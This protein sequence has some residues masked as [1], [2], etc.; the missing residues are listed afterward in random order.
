MVEL[1]FDALNTI[2]NT[3]ITESGVIQGINIDSREIALG[4][5][6]VAI[7]GQRVDG[8]EYIE[9]AF[10]KG[11]SAALVSRPVKA[12]IPCFVVPDVVLALGKIAMYWREQFDIPVIGLTGSNG[13]TTTKNMI[14]MI[15]QK[16]C[17]DESDKVLATP[18]TWN[19]QISLP[20]NLCHLNQSHRYAVLEMGMD[21]FGEISALTH[22]VQPQVAMVLNAFPS[23][24]AG[25]GTVAGVA[26]AKAEIFEGLQEGGTAVLNADS[27]FY[28]YWRH[29]ASTFH[30]VTFGINAIAAVRAEQIQ[31]L[32]DS[33]RFVL[34]IDG[35]SVSIRLSLLGKHNVM[36]AL[37]AAAACSSIGLDLKT[38]RAGLEAVKPELQRLQLH[39]SKEG[40]CI[41]DDSYNAN[42]ASLAAAIDVLARR[43]GVKI[44][45]LGDMK[46]LGDTERQLHQE[47][48]RY[49]KEA[50][51]DYLY[52]VG[53]LTK[54]AVEAFGEGALFFPSKAALVEYLK[55]RLQ[56]NMSVLAKGSHF[57][58]HMEEVVHS[59][60]K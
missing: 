28:D 48:G 19:N 36:N 52:A 57:S 54:E 47:M 24:L 39:F 23:H 59:L 4:N 14:A 41:L 33:S 5:L 7:K 49:A 6:F 16:A 3:H 22:I 45:A 38:I 44:L 25:V 43:P 32:E 29:Q 31:L 60:L 51:I 56:K 12:S 2:L 9:K 27:P 37:G 35:Q 40:A 42:P 15:L 30:Q 58:M 20:L 55:P 8:H 46:E 10:E 50:G 26:K 1:S 34:C 11:A 17:G 18:G 13:K 53:E 21:H